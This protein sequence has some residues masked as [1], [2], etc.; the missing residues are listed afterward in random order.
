MVDV[1]GVKPVECY[2]TGLEVRLD[3]VCCVFCC[4]C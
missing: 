2:E 4:S 1:A 3:G